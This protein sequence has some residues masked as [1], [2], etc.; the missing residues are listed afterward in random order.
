MT[1]LA[2]NAPGFQVARGSGGVFQRVGPVDAGCHG[3]TSISSAT[4]SVTRSLPV[5]AAAKAGL[6]AYGGHTRRNPSYGL[7]SG[8]RPERQQ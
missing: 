1:V 8:A 6:S 7:R 2:R 3:P 5:R 4:G